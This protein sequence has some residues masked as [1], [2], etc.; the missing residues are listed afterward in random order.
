MQAVMQEN[1]DFQKKCDLI[2]KLLNNI[3]SHII[4]FGFENYDTHEL[5]QMYSIAKEKVL[6]RKNIE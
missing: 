1:D 2:D 4:N 6:I 5:A 3:K